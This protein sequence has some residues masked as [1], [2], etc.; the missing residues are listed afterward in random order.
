MKRN[1]KAPCSDTLCPK[2]D[3]QNYT[4]K[5]QKHAYYF[6]DCIEHLKRI[7]SNAK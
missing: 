6:P 2:K 1:F 4:T 5:F 3:C 7:K